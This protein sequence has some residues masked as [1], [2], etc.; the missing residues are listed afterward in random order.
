VLASADD[1]SAI[2]F[3]SECSVIAN[4]F[5]LREPDKLHID[6]IARL[7][8]L[9]PAEIRAQRPDIKY[10]FVRRRDFSVIEDD[11]VAWISAENPIAKQ[12]FIDETP[13]PGYTL[14]KTIRRR[15]G[16]DG[17]AGTYARLYKVAPN[18]TLAVQ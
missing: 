9:P 5:I 17:V 18:D 4:N 10:V 11:N 16:E 15:I 7:M 2:L 6:E 3:H 14:I 13:P 8:R 12:L 1:G